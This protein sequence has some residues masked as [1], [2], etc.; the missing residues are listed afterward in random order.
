MRDRVA[1]EPGKVDGWCGPQDLVR[2][3]TTGSLAEVKDRTF[4][5][6]TS[7]LDT[8]RALNLDIVPVLQ[9]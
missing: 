3:H 2:L 6:G 1:A 5:A 7:L 9:C 4:F 8:F